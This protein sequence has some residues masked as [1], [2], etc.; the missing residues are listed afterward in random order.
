MWRRVWPAIIEIWGPKH[1]QRAVRSN[2]W[3][4][5]MRL[6]R[7]RM[8]QTVMTLGLVVLGPILVVSTFLAFGPFSQNASSPALRLVLLAD[9]VYILVV[10]ALVLQRVARMVADRRSQSAGSRLHL[11]LSDPD[12][13]GGGVCSSDG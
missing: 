9:L 8:V 11:R 2:T 1:V 13:A 5:L 12:C 3:V 6:R 4:R 10:A 7:L